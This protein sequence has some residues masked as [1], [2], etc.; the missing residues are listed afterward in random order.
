MGIDVGLDGLADFVNTGVPHVVARVDDLK[1]VDIAAVGKRLRE[2]D[3]FAPEGTNANFVQVEGDGTLSVRTYER[4]V[5]AETLACGTG[6]VA[7]ALVAARHGWTGLPTTVHCAGGYDLM[8]DSSEGTT[9][10]AGGA[11]VVFD[12]E[13]SYGNRI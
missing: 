3:R 6:A 10:L 4:G 11:E 13:V 2:H 8:I 12:G 7:V 5:E 1:N 9:T